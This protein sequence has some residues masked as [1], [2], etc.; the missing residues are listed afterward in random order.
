MTDDKLSDIE[1]KV[2]NSTL[3]FLGEANNKDEQKEYVISMRKYNDAL[4]FLVENR[5]MAPRP[6]PFFNVVLFNDS[7]TIKISK[8]ASY[9][10]FGDSQEEVKLRTD[11]IE[12]LTKDIPEIKDRIE[13]KED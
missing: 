8:D 11:Y 12:R 10:Y 9:T 13:V 2:I 1:V 3:N 4:G 5:H 7:E 6:Q